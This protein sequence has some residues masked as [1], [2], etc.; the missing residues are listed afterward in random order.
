[1]N[2]T[3]Y[4][5]KELM[6]L[7]IF[8]VL[9][10]LL[11]TV[12]IG[13]N[14]GG[15]FGGWGGPAGGG[16]PGGGSP[17]GGS[18]GGGSSGGGIT[19]SVVT[20]IGRSGPRVTVHTTPG[21][22][23]GYAPPLP[24]MYSPPNY[25]SPSR[26]SG[27][28]NQGNS[29]SNNNSNSSNSGNNSS[30][31]NE[32]TNGGTIIFK[33]AVEV[34]KEDFFAVKIVQG[35]F[36]SSYVLSLMQGGTVIGVVEFYAPENG[37]FTRM[38]V[39]VFASS[40]NSINY[41]DTYSGSPDEM[42]STQASDGNT[43]TTGSVDINS[44]PPTNSN[45]S[46]GT[47]W[48]IAFG[49][50]G[51]STAGGPGGFVNE[52]DRITP[53]I[54]TYAEGCKA[55][56]GGAYRYID[57]YDLDWIKDA[58][59]DCPCGP[60]VIVIKEKRLQDNDSD[61]INAHEDCDDNY[62][63]KENNCRSETE[64]NSNKQKL[65]NL[66]N[67][68]PSVAAVKKVHSDYRSQTSVLLKKVNTSDNDI[69]DD[70]SDNIKESVDE[71]AFN[72]NEHYRQSLETSN[73][74]KKS[75][76]V[77]Y[78][79]E[80]LSFDDTKS[81]GKSTTVLGMLK[82]FKNALKQYWPKNNDEWAAIA[83]IMAPL[84]IEVGLAAI[85][86]SEI[87]DIVRGINDNDYWAVGIATATLAGT[88]FGA[89]IIKVLGKLGQ[90]MR[91]TF[92]IVRAVGD[93]LSHIKNV[94]SKG[95]KTSIDRFGQVILKKGDETLYKGDEV[96]D[97]VTHISQELPQAGTR[98]G[99]ALSSLAAA[100]NLPGIAAG[101]GKNITGKWL[102]GTDGNAGKFPKSVADQM[103]GKNYQN[104]NKF[105]EDF[106]KNVADDPHL[107]N[108]FSEGN[109]ALMKSGK[110]PKVKNTQNV[111]GQNTYQLHHNTPINQGGDVYNFDNLTI[112]TPRYHKEILSPSYHKGYGY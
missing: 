18:H 63:S 55:S 74:I 73:I 56:C 80:D 100:R 65:R 36:S 23:R 29:G 12:A 62:Y 60:G 10:L 111:G 26:P 64:S 110:A 21:T 11:S 13:Q 78:Q 22:Y 58:V 25:T 106:W 90:Q 42:S 14:E 33:K 70:I 105:R 8:T 83:Q 82:E 1:M 57:D 7:R 96:K 72:A 32:A 37:F 46:L 89:E 52:A 67:N 98:S 66:A 88:I 35:S 79:W 48:T 61:G 92:K 69:R 101:N 4:K 68:P 3:I 31:K 103:K 108:Q 43:V 28:G 44:S 112:V 5:L 94:I 6:N 75:D 40:P 30:S 93:S 39:E 97:A 84:L 16:S 9:F 86:G 85:P 76:A 38:R 109:K 77:D 54:D 17:G 27:G 71:N 104:F 107:A 50:D 99:E 59:K 91:K 19:N 34:G 95:F 24:T 49:N 51:G 53:P 81:I 102:R 87:I 45:G 15:G 41:I 2:T 20:V 47:P